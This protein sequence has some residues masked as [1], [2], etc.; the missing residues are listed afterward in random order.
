M[1]WVAKQRIPRGVRLPLEVIMVEQV[2][3]LQ[4]VEDPT[5]ENLDIPEGSCRYGES[6]Q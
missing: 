3:T 2:S 5:L 6:M 1:F 4:Y